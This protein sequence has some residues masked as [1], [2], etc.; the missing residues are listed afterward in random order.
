[1]IIALAAIYTSICIIKKMTIRGL[2][3]LAVS[4][5]IVIL[6]MNFETNA[7]KLIY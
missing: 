6:V 4:G 5:I 3:V 7:N 2:I 1:M